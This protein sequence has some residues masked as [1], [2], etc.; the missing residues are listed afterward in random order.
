MYHKPL[1]P[2][3]EAGAGRDSV[4]GVYR[5]QVRDALPVDPGDPL[6]ARK[7]PIIKL[8]CPHRSHVTS[9]FQGPKFRQGRLVLYLTTLT[10]TESEMRFQ[11]TQV[12]PQP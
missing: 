10:E 3:P 12:T 6:E 7:G 9:R 8:V 1:T 2:N 11:W 4:L 5:D